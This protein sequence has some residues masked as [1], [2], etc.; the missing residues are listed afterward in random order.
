MWVD[1][2]GTVQQSPEPVR[3]CAWSRQRQPKSRLLRLVLDPDGRPHVDLTGKAPGRGVYVSPDRDLLRQ[4]L[5]PKGMRR[6]FRGSVPGVREPDELL[7]EVEARLA[8]R[9]LDHIGLARRAGQLLVGAEEVSKA[10]A[11]S[12][13][14][15]VLLAEDASDRTAR[16]I[17]KAAGEVP[18]LRLATS[19]A[20]GVKLGRGPTA[21]LG[22]LPSVFVDRIVADGERHQRLTNEGAREA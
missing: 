5:S 14:P 18:I 7:A 22:V 21:V 2:L 16:Q 13:V 20:F 17:T 1:D 3:T 19:E 15:V 6:L 11:R 10:L 8:A 4:A 12:S 9:L